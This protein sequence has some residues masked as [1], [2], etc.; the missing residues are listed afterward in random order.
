MRNKIQF[1]ENDTLY[2]P[3]SNS[4]PGCTRGHS[5]LKTVECY[6]PQMNSWSDV[7]PLLVPRSGACAVA[8]DNC[9]VVIGGS[10]EKKPLNSCEI[11]DLG[12]GQWEY[13]TCE[14]INK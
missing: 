8:F 14:L 6:N 11:Y 1:N 7:A 9:I 5:S 4:F 12:K 2:K 10:N 3:I 13:I